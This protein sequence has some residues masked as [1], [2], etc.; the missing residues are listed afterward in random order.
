M[1]LKPANILL[2]KDMTLKI[3][4]FGLSRLFPSANTFTTIKIIGTPGYMPPEYIEKHEITPKFDVFSLGVIIIRIIAGDEGYSKSANMSSQEFVEDVHGNWRKRMQ[5]IMTSH[6]SLEIVTCIEIALRCVETDRMRRPTISEIVI[7]LKEIDTV[8]SS[9]ISQWLGA[10]DTEDD[11]GFEYSDD[12]PIVAPPCSETRVQ[13]MIKKFGNKVPLYENNMKVVLQLSR[14][15]SVGRLG[16]DMVVVLDISGSM[17][18]KKIQ[19]MKTAMKFIIDKLSSID[20]LSIVT[21]SAAAARLCPLRLITESSQSELQEIISG[22]TA[23]GDTANIIDGLQTGFKVLTDRKVSRSRVVAVIIMSDGLQI[24]RGNQVDVDGSD[25]PVYTFGFGSD[26]DPTVLHEVAN[27]SNGGTFSA[28][29][30]DMDGQSLA[31]SRCLGKLLTVV[32][33]DLRLTVESM[34]KECMLSINVITDGSHSQTQD[35]NHSLVTVS[36][37]N[38]HSWEVRNITVSLLLPAIKS[39]CS[40]EILKITYS[41]STFGELFVVPPSTMTVWRTDTSMEVREKEKPLAVPTKETHMQQMV[42]KTASDDGDYNFLLKIVLTGNSGVGKSNILSRFVGDSSTSFIT[43]VGIDLK[44][45]IVELDGRRIKLQIWDTGKERYRALIDAYYRE[46]MG[47]LL[48]YDVN[49]IRMWNREIEEYAPTGANKI[50]VGNKIDMAERQ[51]L[52]ASRGQALADEYGIKFFETSAKTNL[53]VEQA[54]ISLVRD[55]M[56]RLAPPE[57]DSIHVDPTIE[58]ETSQR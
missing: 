29:I 51:A 45:R 41:Y 36:L 5:E 49:S 42:K 57:N 22:L 43:T 56:Q 19:E 7:K 6:A 32:V 58:V 54:F 15:G 8:E 34:E 33:Q 48:V 20:R 9:P 12:E 50:L 26:H 46:A 23:S 47:I 25:V 27:K 39:E 40:M 38:L 10:E 52:L 3:G 14:G 28:V 24:N 2:D 44:T 4:D 18:G 55:I 53:N 17:Q 16:L 31:F 21:F 35:T 13:L 1:D 11:H 37:G 30:Q